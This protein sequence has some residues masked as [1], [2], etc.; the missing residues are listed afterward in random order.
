MPIDQPVSVG[1]RNAIQEDISALQG[2]QQVVVGSPGRVLELMQLGALTF[3]GIKVLVIDEA[4]EVFAGFVEQVHATQWRMPLSVQVVFSSVTTPQNE[5]EE[6]STVPDLLHI[7]VKHTGRPLTGIK[8]SYIAIEDENQKLDI[9]SDLLQNSGNTTILIFRNLR[10]NLEWLAE[11]LQSRG[12]VCSYMQGDM[13]AIERAGI[14]RDFRSGSTCVLLATN[15][16]AR[17]LDLRPVEVQLVVNYDLPGK[18][19]D[20]IHR[21]TYDS[22]F[23]RSGRTVSLVAADEVK[24]I[25]ELE[26]HY[27]TQ[28]EETS[29]P[30]LMQSIPPVA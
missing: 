10:R 12:I 4:D 26:R 15:M 14:V 22:R 5:S 23:G 29:V 25:R 13:T 8:Q 11:Q 3:E 20:Y 1:K 21:T 7:V 19:E 18:N 30:L 9:L 17:G 16:L 27:S 24:R 6:S 28:I 2:G